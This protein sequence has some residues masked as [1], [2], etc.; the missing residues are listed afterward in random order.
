MI[1]SDQTYSP[2]KHFASAVKIPAGWYLYRP[3]VSDQLRIMTSRWWISLWIGL[4]AL[5]PIV[6]TIIISIHCLKAVVEL[7]CRWKY[8]KLTIYA[9]TIITTE[10]ISSIWFKMCPSD[11]V[12]SVTRNVCDN[13]I[14]IKQ[15]CTADE[16]VGFSR[17]RLHRISNVVVYLTAWKI[18]DCERIK[19][20]HA[21]GGRYFDCMK[22]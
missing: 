2:N 3:A 12:P 9:L 14:S 6:W 5:S 17:I 21:L 11:N 20:L 10:R 7:K 4:G 22:K 1:D 8:K 15:E 13:T 19:L 16:V 18:S